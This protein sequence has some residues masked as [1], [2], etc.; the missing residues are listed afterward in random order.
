ME[1]ENNENESMGN[2][3]VVNVGEEPPIFSDVSTAQN[4]EKML[5]LYDTLLK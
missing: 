2:G 4:G 3:K 5:Y 1:V